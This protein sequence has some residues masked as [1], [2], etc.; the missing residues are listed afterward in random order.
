[1]VTDVVALFSFGFRVYADFLNLLVCTERAIQYTKLELEDQ[2]VKK[3]DS[4]KEG[5]PEN[6]NI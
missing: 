6:G 5:W 4:K 3:D 1:M 2:L